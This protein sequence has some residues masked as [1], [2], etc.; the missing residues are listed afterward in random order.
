MP[1]GIIPGEHQEAIAAFMA[2]LTSV[3]RRNSLAAICSLVR[4]SDLDRFNAEHG[5]S[6]EPYPLAAYGCMVLAAR[7]TRIRHEGARGAMSARSRRK[8]ARTENAIVHALQ[9]AGLA[10]E[11]SSRSGY[12]GHDITVPLLGLEP[13]LSRVTLPPSNC[14]PCW[15]TSRVG[16]R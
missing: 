11:K 13:I 14:A 10:A 7:Q 3:V 2:D 15:P 16:S 12:T 4:Q 8:G 9:D 1:N 5:V 6:L